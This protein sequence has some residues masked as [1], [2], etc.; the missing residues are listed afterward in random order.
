MKARRCLSTAMSLALVCL[1]GVQSVSAQTL[2]KQRTAPEARVLG[3]HSFIPSN[4]VAW[5]F[6]STYFG[7]STGVGLA[8]FQRAGQDEQG[9]PINEKMSLAAFA[10]TF[11]IGI[12]ITSWLGLQA[13][14]DGLINAGGDLESALN[15]GAIFS[16]NNNIGVIIRVVNSDQ[17]TLAARFGGSYQTGKRLQP[18]EMLQTDASGNLTLDRKR[19]L[20]D[21]DAWT[22][23]PAVMAAWAPVRYLGL[24]TSLGFEYGKFELGD[25]SLDTKNADLGLGRQPRRPQRRHA[26]RHPAG[27]SAAKGL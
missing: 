3:D 27:L 7:M 11:S 24:Q 4:L 9:Q 23:G 12:A 26:D 14:V 20:S 16:V 19:L 10:E 25:A 13:R 21:L 1:L 17:F 22:V 15:V 18:L 2:S 8:R 5:P 6:V